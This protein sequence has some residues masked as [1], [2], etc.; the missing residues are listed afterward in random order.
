MRHPF[1]LHQYIRIFFI[2]NITTYVV[3]APKKENT[4]KVAGNAKV[5]ESI[6]RQSP[7]DGE[8]DFA[9]KAEAAAAKAAVANAQVAAREDDE[10]SKGAKSNAK[11]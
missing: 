5:R 11:K 8:A 9:Q 4:K 7:S 2:V 10:W 6:S 1:G 3:M